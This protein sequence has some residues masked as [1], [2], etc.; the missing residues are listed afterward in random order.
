MP[1]RLFSTLLPF[2]SNVGGARPLPFFPNWNRREYSCSHSHYPLDSTRT[3]IVE[4]SPAASQ[5]DAVSVA[6]IFLNQTSASHQDRWFAEHTTSR[7]AA[8]LRGTVPSLCC[9]SKLPSQV[10]SPTF[11]LRPSTLDARFAFHAPRTSY[12]ALKSLLFY[13][14]RLKSLILIDLADTHSATPFISIFYEF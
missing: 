5:A 7:P 14:L 8:R 1:L 2:P 12:I 11:D 4:Q 6:Q 10:I 13:I 9:Y 3:I